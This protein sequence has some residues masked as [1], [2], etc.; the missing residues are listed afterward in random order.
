MRDRRTLAARDGSTSAPHPTTDAVTLTRRILL[1][2]LAGR[3][4]HG[5]RL[6]EDRRRERPVPAPRP[7]APRP[8]KPF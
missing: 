1:T 4:A 5:L 3:R 7:I 6:R 2:I 8:I